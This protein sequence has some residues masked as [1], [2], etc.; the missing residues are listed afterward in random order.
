MFR[1]SLSPGCVWNRLSDLLF[2][3]TCLLC[4][5]PGAGGYDLCAGCAA[6]LPHNCDACWRCAR[7]LGAAGPVD[8]LCGRC[9]R[10]APP[11]VRTLAALRYETPVPSL[12]GAMKFNGR[13]NHARLLGQ[14]L[15]DAARQ[16]TPPWPQVLVPVPL[17][18]HRLAARGFNQSAEIARVVGRTLGL[19]LETG[20]VHRVLATPPQAGL[21][22]AARRRNIRGAFMARRP[23][24]W[25]RVAILDDVVT[26]GATVTELSRVLLQAG[27]ESVEVWAAVRTP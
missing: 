23:W 10:R 21:D 1:E 8:G 17:H 24:P 26:T 3:P 18:R 2:P 6:A 15:A 19:P 13:L 9:Q 12:V 11:F 22:E 16:L 4:G 5:A 25:A 20:V 27:A 7:P 14:I